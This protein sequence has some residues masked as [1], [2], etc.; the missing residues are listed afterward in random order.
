MNPLAKAKQQRAEE[1]EKLRKE[2]ESLR[3]RLQL[4][5]EGGCSPEDASLL[6]KLSPEAGP[7][8]VKQ[9]EGQSPLIMHLSVMFSPKG[10]GHRVGTLTFFEKKSQIP[11]PRDDIFGQKY[12]IPHPH[13][14]KGWLHTSNTFKFPHPED[15]TYDQHPHPGDKP[16][17]LD[18]Y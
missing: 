15:I 8:V 10:V 1:L 5:E 3:R 18:N 9:V 6:S 17:V 13:T 2:N 12:Q 14:G 11:H 4:L 7:S 16:H